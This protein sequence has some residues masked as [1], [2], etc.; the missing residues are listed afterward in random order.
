[1]KPALKLSS[2]FFAG[3]LM[4]GMLALLVAGCGGGVTTSAL[5]MWAWMGGSSTANSNGN[6]GTQGAFAGTN[7]PGARSAAA[8]WRDG[9]GNLWLFGGFGYDGFSTSPDL[10]NDLWEYNGSGWA[11]IGGSNAAGAAG[12]YGVLGKANTANIPG[13]RQHALSWAD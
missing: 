7:I 2:R 5:G 3:L 9:S 8:H 1:M 12:V 6:Y 10:L 4:T 11:W 13:A